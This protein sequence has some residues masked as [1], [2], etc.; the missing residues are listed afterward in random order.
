MGSIFE[1]PI[2]KTLG[3][4]QVKARYTARELRNLF[5]L[6]EKTLRRWTDEHLLEPVER[7]P[8]LVFDFT[9][10]P[11]LRR[12]REMRAEGYSLQRIEEE[13]RG[14]LNLF[15]SKKGPAS[16]VEITS[17][18]TAFRRALLCQDRDADAAR[19]L[20]IDSINAGTY[21]SDAY[22]NLGLLEYQSGRSSRA[23]NCLTQGLRHD[24]RHVESHYNLGSIYYDLGDHVLARLHL[25]LVR[26]IEPSYPCAHFNLALVYGKLGDLVGAF[27]SLRAYQS[28]LPEPDEEIEALLAKVDGCELSLTPSD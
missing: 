17:R 15:A 6:Q 27:N 23:I 4:Q 16:V 24:P 22:C 20:Y 28:L 21:Q 11:I 5:G 19:A 14:Q 12:V 9:A 1:F 2:E 8:E 26:E 10:L 3:Y 7:T 25:E 13:L 18:E